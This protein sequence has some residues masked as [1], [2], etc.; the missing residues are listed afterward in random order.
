[1]KH[2]DLCC[3]EVCKIASVCD[4]G[5]TKLNCCA[6][7][8]LIGTS[9]EMIYCWIKENSVT[10]TRLTTRKTAMPLLC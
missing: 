5:S 3:C 7:M 4:S 1:M 6:G 9:Q 10:F 2:V 8:S